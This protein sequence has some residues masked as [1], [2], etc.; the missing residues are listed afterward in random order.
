MA[1]AFCLVWWGFVGEAGPGQGCPGQELL[2]R[3]AC[4]GMSTG[5]HWGGVSDSSKVDGD[6]QKWHAL[7]LCQ[8]GRRK[9]RKVV[10]TSASVLEKFPTD[11][12]PSGTHPKISH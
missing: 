8:E 2:W 7:A 4:R 6:C 5:E 12:Y 1:E 3:G 10:P 11:P 9:T